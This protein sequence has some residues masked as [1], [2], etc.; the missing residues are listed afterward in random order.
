[1]EY[2][3]PFQE[4]S[5]T[6]K[7]LVWAKGEVIPHYEPSVWR[8]D[9]YGKVMRYN[10]H[11]NTESKFGWEIDHIYPKELGGTDDLEN[12]QPLQWKNNRSKS[13]LIMWNG[14][15]RFFGNIESGLLL[16]WI[17]RSIKKSNFNVRN[18]LR[19]IKRKSIYH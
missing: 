9:K 3:Y 15:K 14:N 5:E 13:D 6:L 11:G 1:M 8:W 4:S 7:K 12:L 16:S 2:K 19:G 17:N 10:K 18:I